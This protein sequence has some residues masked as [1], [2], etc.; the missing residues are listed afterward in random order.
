V[1]IRSV[2]VDDTAIPVD[3]AGDDA[4]DYLAKIAQQ[5]V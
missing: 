3:E 1:D 5:A 4:V 2:P